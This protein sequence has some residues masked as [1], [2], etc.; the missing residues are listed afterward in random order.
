MKWLGLDWDG[1]LTYQSRRL[2]VYNSYVDKLLAS[3]HA[4][5]CDCSPEEVEAFDRQFPAKEKK[6][7]PG[8]LSH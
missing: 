2:D 5:W 3:G 7:L 4:Y 1:E 8:Q 6:V